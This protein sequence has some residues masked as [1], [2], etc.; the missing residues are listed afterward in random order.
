MLNLHLFLPSLW[1]QRRH[2]IRLKVSVELV[3]KTDQNL[4]GES[5]TAQ[6]HQNRLSRS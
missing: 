1:K 3:S 5:M 6:K 2:P 4:G